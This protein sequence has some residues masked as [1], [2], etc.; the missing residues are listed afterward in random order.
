MT[1]EP[2]T[3]DTRVGRRDVYR[4]ITQQ[5]VAAIEAGAGTFTMPW[6][7][8]VG[9]SQPTNALT[10]NVYNGV[11]VIALWAAAQ[12]RGFV[13]GHWAT[14]KQWRL[15][16]AQVRKGE[17]GS[18][19]VFFKETAR[20]PTD[21]E[22]GDVEEKPVRYARSSIVFNAEQVDGWQVPR[23]VAPDP[24]TVQHQV[25]AFVT[26][27]AADIRSGGA[28]AYYQ[29]QAD[30]IQMPARARF[31]G[32]ATRSA[33]ESYYAILLHELTHWTGHV[34]RLDRDLSGR[35]GDA[36]YAMEELV[37]ELGAAFLCAELGISQVPRPDHAAYVAHWL[38][39]MRQD[40][41][42][43]FTAARHASQARS[44]L[45]GLQPPS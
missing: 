22:T 39:V 23:P 11:N 34:S 44:Y 36:G 45:N 41:R 37:A 24:V 25:E 20:A 40:T 9:H 19:V 18:V 33:T 35:F 32:T 15:L 4:A 21:P 43:I 12:L 14:Y 10:G 17:T 16:G 3:P 42:A 1:H 31:T 2:A 26:A 7:R 13:S 27:T 6:H 5:I 29:P 38:T 28:H 30:H 8:D